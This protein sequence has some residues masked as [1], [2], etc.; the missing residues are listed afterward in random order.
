MSFHQSC[1]AHKNS[2]YYPVG[3][4]P[5]IIEYYDE[6]VTYDTNVYKAN[7]KVSL[8][9]EKGVL[10]IDSVEYTDADG[11][12]L[13]SIKIINIKNEVTALVSKKWVNADGTTDWPKGVDAV[14]FMVSYGNDYEIVKLTADEPSKKTGGRF[15]DRGTVLSSFTVS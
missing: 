11:N 3:E 13:D 5:N 2:I 14:L 10:S 9:R 4:V 15:E 1:N 6:N 7:V 8:D 12:K